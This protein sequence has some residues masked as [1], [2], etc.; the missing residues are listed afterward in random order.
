MNNCPICN[1]DLELVKNKDAHVN[2]CMENN[3]EAIG[4]GTSQNLLTLSGEFGN[5]E[6]YL[7][8]CPYNNCKFKCD[9]SFFPT[10][11]ISTH[12][13]E[14]SHN[15]IC[16][17]CLKFEQNYGFNPKPDSSL[18]DHLAYR[19]SE[20]I[21]IFEQKDLCYNFEENEN[22]SKK[23]IETKKNVIEFK[24][25][26]PTIEYYA[27]LDVQPHDYIAAKVIIDVPDL[28]CSICFENFRR[29]DITARLV[30]MCLY[31]QKC[32]EDWYRI[33]MKRECPLHSDML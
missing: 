7:I 2:N 12:G 26:P 23:E 31:H 18:L 4:L 15:F 16:P 32:I 11:A 24:E 3:N 21:G 8:H 10:H 22:Q 27:N 28:E 33:K 5:S 30:C 29:T 19:H 9:A 20:L 13:R 25:T 14:M 17:I 1:L 6:E